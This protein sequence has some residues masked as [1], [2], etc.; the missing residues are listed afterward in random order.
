MADKNIQ[1]ALKKLDPANNDHWTSTKQPSVAAVSELHGEQVSRA[2]I[3]SA[4]DGFSRDTAAGYFMTTG[5]PQADGTVTHPTDSV[6]ADGTQQP[7]GSTEGADAEGHRPVE[8]LADRGTGSG[9]TE[10]TET[11]EQGRVINSD[12]RL[13]DSDISQGS[14][15]IEDG[16]PANSTAA[17][18]PAVDTVQGDENVCGVDEGAQKPWENLFKSGVDRPVAPDSE[19]GQK[20]LNDQRPTEVH[21]EEARRLGG[22]FNVEE[23]PGQDVNGNVV[24]VRIPSATYPEVDRADVITPGFDGD[25]I[26]V[27]DRPSGL[28]VTVAEGHFNLHAAP[29]NPATSAALADMGRSSREVRAPEEG[30][31]SEGGE[32]GPASD[33]ASEQSEVAGT[34]DSANKVQALEADLQKREA[35]IADLRMKANDA[36]VAWR[37]AEQDADKLRIQIAHLRPTDSDSR[38][39]SDYL[40]SRKNELEER[41]QRQQALKDAGVN[42]ADVLKGV[43][44]SPIDTAMARKTGRGGQRPSRV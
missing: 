38:T 32:G 11:T 9:P 3:D 28:P 27:E 34:D 23:N 4:A 19:E 41:G 18:P 15:R 33:G 7:G 8:G 12:D 37:E 14:E 44:A 36:N 25:N 31:D 42:L 26:D 6:Q 20:V 29:F 39:I 43:N 2:D 35:N 13:K 5:S 17:L 40:E 16:R 24:G 22:I 1:D 10:G 30:S 21:E